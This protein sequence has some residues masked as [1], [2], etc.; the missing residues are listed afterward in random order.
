MTTKKTKSEL[1]LV[2]STD[3]HL[4]LPEAEE[5]LLFEMREAWT[6]RRVG[7]LRHTKKAVRQD[8]RVVNE[9]ISFSSRPPWRWTMDDFDRWCYHL[10]VERR[11]GESTQRKYQ[12]AI[13]KFLDY[14]ISSPRFT[15]E[16]ESQ[17][18]TSLRQIVTPENSVPHIVEDE[19]KTFR[20]PLTQEQVLAFFSSLDKEISFAKDAGSK[21]FRP[22]QRDKALFYTMYVTAARSN[23]IRTLKVNSFMS[24]PNNP[25]F[26]DFGRMFV[27]GKGS[28]GSGPVQRSI[29]IDHVDLPPI[30]S[31][32]T[33]FVRPFFARR[34]DPNEDSF[35]LSERG[36][37]LCPAS[38]NARFSKHLENANLDGLGFTPH[39]L[40]HS[41]ITHGRLQTTVEVQ[42]RKAGHAFPATTESYT[43]FE[44]SFYEKQIQD[45]IESQLDKN[46]RGE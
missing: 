33:K 38:I 45:V 37:Q 42:Q 5:S 9:F 28:K 29:K 32:Y 6:N 14:L 21:D 4:D 36:N 31:W 2:W 35:F 12:S 19:A 40:R 27:W 43:Y 20:R 41:S 10:G 1:R 30:L 24:D 17:F 46:Q 3:D 13:K 34:A 18:R 16:V 8:H 23:E 11:L 25:E 15:H 44:T 22:L 39:C 7:A 26:G